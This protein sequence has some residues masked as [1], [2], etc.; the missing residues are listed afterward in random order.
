MSQKQSVNLNSIFKS[1]QKV[2]DKILPNEESK[3]QEPIVSKSIVQES[4]NGP[5]SKNYGSSSHNSI[6]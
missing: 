3:I 2:T 1:K 6:A 4:E 5:I